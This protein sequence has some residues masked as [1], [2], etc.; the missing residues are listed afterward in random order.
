MLPSKNNRRFLLFRQTA[1]LF[2]LCVSCKRYIDKVSPIITELILTNHPHGFL[3]DIFDS[4][5]RECGAFKVTY[6][7]NAFCPFLN[8]GVLYWGDVKQSVSVGVSL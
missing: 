6:H 8:L 1:S 5:V 2:Q 7:G 3:E 4:L